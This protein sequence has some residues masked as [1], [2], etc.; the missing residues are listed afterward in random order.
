MFFVLLSL[1]VVARA[2]HRAATE[3]VVSKDLRSGL[4]SFASL[5]RSGVLT[6]L[7]INMVNFGEPSSTTLHKAERSSSGW[8]YS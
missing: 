5:S 7:G 1:G 3:L 6:K 2:C 8:K 4:L